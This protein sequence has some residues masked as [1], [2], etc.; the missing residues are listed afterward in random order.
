[1]KYIAESYED[2]W[3][4]AEMLVQGEITAEHYYEATELWAKNGFKDK[5]WKSWIDTESIRGDKKRWWKR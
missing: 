3:K 2:V 4:L 5:S 1:M